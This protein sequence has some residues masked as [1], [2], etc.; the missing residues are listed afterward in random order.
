MNPLRQHAPADHA[1]LAGPATEQMLAA[2]E[3]RMGIPLPQDL[4]A[5]LLQ[6]NL[7]LP[8]EDA[9][10]DVACCGFAG[11]PDEGNFFLG[12][13]AVEKLCANRFTPGGFE[14]PDRTAC[15]QWP[16]TDRADVAVEGGVRSL[17][18]TAQE[19]CWCPILPHSTRVTPWL[20]FSA[21]APGW[22]RGEALVHGDLNGAVQGFIGG[23][24]AYAAGG[25][26]FTP[27]TIAGRRARPLLGRA[28]PSTW[29]EG[30]VPGCSQE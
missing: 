9:D 19:R 4:R 17:D 26:S 1:D 20:N 14:P 22:A 16:A 5:W 6:N 27:T 12:I 15:E 30:L 13:R 3:E 7:D 24:P 8:E 2:A 11:F 28:G 10:D 25:T 29:T 23:T 18:P 21:T